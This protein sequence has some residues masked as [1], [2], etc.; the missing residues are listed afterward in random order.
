MVRSSAQAAAKRKLFL[1]RYVLC[2]IKDEISS[3]TFQLKRLRW[4]MSYL[5][6]ATGMG[7]RKRVM[8]WRCRQTMM[9]TM[10]TSRAEPNHSNGA[11]TIHLGTICEILFVQFADDI[12]V[13]QS[14]HSAKVPQRQ[15]QKH[16]FY[17]VLRPFTSS[18]SSLFIFG[19]HHL[20][21]CD[22]Q[23]DIVGMFIVG[24][25][26]FLCTGC[27]WVERERHVWWIGLE[28]VSR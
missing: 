25:T 12:I 3:S 8:C 15:G 24:G 9:M 13:N 28:N 2:H 1:S 22:K 7:Q 20:C 23:S 16:N 18:L 27:D 17:F 5:D 4:N 11:V 14:F 26:S 10:M 21:V 19:F 6:W